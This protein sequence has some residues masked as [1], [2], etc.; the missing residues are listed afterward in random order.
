MTKGQTIQARGNQRPR[1]NVI[2]PHAPLA[3]ALGLLE[4][5]YPEACSL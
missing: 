3:G 1:L 4:F 2:D 5:D